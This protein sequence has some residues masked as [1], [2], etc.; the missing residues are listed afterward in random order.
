MDRLK[1]LNDQHGHLTG[2][3]AVRAVG[4]IIGQRLPPGAVACRYGGDEFAIAIP[5]CTSRQGHE[6][7]DDLCRAVHDSAP[8]LAGRP[9]AAGTLSISVGGTCALVDGSTPTRAIS[10][11]DI[12]VGE[13]LFQAADA[14]LYRAKA[15]GRNRVWV[16]EGDADGPSTQTAPQTIHRAAPRT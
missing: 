12:D 7:A 4:R 9:F 13:A 3:E 6:V 10:P 5:R 16:N 1:S 8:V 2:A 14:A 11:R 15:S